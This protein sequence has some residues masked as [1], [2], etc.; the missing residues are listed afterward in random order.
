MLCLAATAAAHRCPLLDL[1][2]YRA[3]FADRQLARIVLASILPRLPVGMNALGLTLFVHS[4]SGSFARAGWVTGAYMAAL[5]VQAPLLGRWVDR[6]GPRGE[7]RAPVLR[8]GRGPEGVLARAHA[9][10]RGG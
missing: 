6:R 5:A 1:S 8:G 9:P 2:A 3:L 7:G 10:A 4:A